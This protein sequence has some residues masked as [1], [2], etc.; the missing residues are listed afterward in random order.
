[1]LKAE[2]ERSTYGEEASAT[3]PEDYQRLSDKHK[4]LV[5][6]IVQALLLA[7]KTK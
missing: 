6:E 7:E 3:L 1:V 5:C 4:T 2:E